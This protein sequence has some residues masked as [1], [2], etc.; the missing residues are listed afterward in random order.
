M[1]LAY[2]YFRKALENPEGMQTEEVFSRYAAD[3]VA[4]LNGKGLTLGEE[5]LAVMN[6]SDEVLAIGTPYMRL[7]ML[8]N[9]GFVFIFLFNAILNGEPSREIVAK[10]L[11]RP[12]TAEQP[13]DQPDIS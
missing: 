11:A 9:F 12:L 8:L 6:V 2:A 13:G 10:L 1:A 7:V 4:Y 5:M 3:V